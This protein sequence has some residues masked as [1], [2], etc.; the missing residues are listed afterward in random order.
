MA[1]SDHLLQKKQL[2]DQQ[3]AAFNER[4]AAHNQRSNQYLR[5][6][7][8]NLRLFD[9]NAR[10]Y[11]QLNKDIE[12][13]N[14][15]CNESNR[16]FIAA[17]AK[18][19]QLQ[20]DAQACIDNNQLDNRKQQELF[21]RLAQTNPTEA[22]RLKINDQQLEQQ[23]DELDRREAQLESE[24]EGLHRAEV[25]LQ[26][27]A[28]NLRND[29][30][31]IEQQR[32]DI[33]A[34]H[35]QYQQQRDSV[36]TTVTGPDG[37]P[38]VDM[39][40]ADAQ[41]FDNGGLAE[42][43]LRQIRG[44][45]VDIG[46][47]AQQSESR[48]EEQQR[49]FQQQQQ[50]PLAPPPLGGVKQEFVKKETPQ[51]KGQLPTPAQQAIAL[52]MRRDEQA[53]L[54]RS[55]LAPPAQ[56]A[57]APGMRRDEQAQLQRNPLA[58][59]AQQAIAPGM[60]RDEQA[61]PQEIQQPQPAPTVPSAPAPPAY[62]N[63]PPPAYEPPER[64]ATQN[65]TAKPQTPKNPGEIE[66]YKKDKEGGLSAKDRS[67]NSRDLTGID[68]AD[69]RD[70]PSPEHSLKGAAASTTPSTVQKPSSEFAKHYEKM[71][72]HDEKAKKAIVKS[73]KAKADGSVHPAMT[74][75]PTLK[76]A[77]TAFS[78]A[79]DKVRHKASNALE[80]IRN[81]NNHSSKQKKTRLGM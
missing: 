53:Q 31:H 79:K 27:R 43:Q 81:T 9:E 39:H 20:K 36:V 44:G 60:R 23:S 72:Q 13:H 37:S 58:P 29:K 26:R 7:N 64:S 67:R 45:E 66:Q 4:V 19:P 47:Q 75:P 78:H 80:G 14:R 46:W 73:A 71:G 65:P 56:Q 68:K 70:A 10:K 77:L 63:D 52:G 32:N 28:A 17:A 1:L 5:D 3:K 30:A 41:P 33:N 59:P 49:Q 61:Q 25:D 38:A 2:L 40:L 69:K 11:D 55:P 57:I 16:D 48:H 18:D 42:E 35:Q 22:Q 51:Q 76:G 12:N 74:K 15:L 54:Q 62:H 24:A 8:E 34:Q 21:D 50:S 6:G